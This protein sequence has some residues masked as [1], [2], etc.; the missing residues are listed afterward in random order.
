MVCFST[1]EEFSKSSA[2]TNKGQVMLEEE[3]EEVAHMCPVTY[4]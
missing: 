3:E 4:K 2:G 1:E